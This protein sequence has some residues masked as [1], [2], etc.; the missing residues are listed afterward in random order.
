MFQFSSYLID[1]HKRK[2]NMKGKQGKESTRQTYD[3]QPLARRLR[4]SP[5]VR[6]LR[7]STGEKGRRGR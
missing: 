1:V 6:W 2:N 4:W 7:P 3:S 5:P